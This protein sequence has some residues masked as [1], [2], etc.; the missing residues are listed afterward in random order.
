MLKLAAYNTLTA[1]E[2]TIHGFVMENEVGV[3]ATIPK[4]E[5]PRTLQIGDKL[6]LFVYMG[7]DNVFL[8]TPLTP[9][10]KV[11]EFGF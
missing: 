7:T 9:K 4:T 10:L 8:A 6:D 5:I 1:V 2:N 11:N 3:K